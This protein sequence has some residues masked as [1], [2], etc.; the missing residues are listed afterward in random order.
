[1]APRLVKALKRIGGPRKI[2][3]ERRLDEITTIRTA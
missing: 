1:M 2:L 3:L